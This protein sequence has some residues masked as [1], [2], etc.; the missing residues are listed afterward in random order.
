MQTENFYYYLAALALIIIAFLVIKRV[1]SCLIRSV[2]G[3]GVLVII[4]YIYW[5]YIRGA[6]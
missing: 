6:A 1:A 3:I 4:A 2:V 5:F